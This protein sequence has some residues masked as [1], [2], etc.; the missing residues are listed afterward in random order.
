M[1]KLSKW[2]KRL[3]DLGFQFPAGASATLFPGSNKLVIRNTPQQL[4]LIA[5]I[6]IG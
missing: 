1:A 4:D 2:T 5:E 6:L 3:V